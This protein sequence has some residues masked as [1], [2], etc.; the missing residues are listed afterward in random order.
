MGE[1]WWGTSSVPALR[2]QKLAE[3]CEFEASMAYKS[4]PGQ[5]GLLDRETVFKSK[6]KQ[7]KKKKNNPS[8]AAAHLQSQRSGIRD[9]RI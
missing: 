4:S 6:T 3:F 9:K 5:P 7:N 1:V 8:G 2:R